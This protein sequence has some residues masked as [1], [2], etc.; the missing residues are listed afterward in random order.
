MEQLRV[1]EAVRSYLVPLY[2]NPTEE[3]RPTSLKAVSETLHIS[4]DTLRKHGI[5]KVLD[6]AERFRRRC[7]PKK[8]GVQLSKLIAQ[9]SALRRELAETTMQYESLLER[10]TKIEDAMKSK[11]GAINFDAIIDSSISKPNRSAPAPTVRGRR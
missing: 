4:R 7:L 1:S 6:E 3:T 11:K 5:A 10:L 2:A 9:N 8:Y